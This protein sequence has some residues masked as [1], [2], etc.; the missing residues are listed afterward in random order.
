MRR[1]AWPRLL[2]LALALFFLLGGFVN[3]VPSAEISADYVRWGYPG[4]FP[5]VT[6]SLELVTAGLLVSS[7]TRMAGV[8]IGTLV[9]LGALATLLFHSELLHALAPLA[10]LAALAG[11]VALSRR[12][13]PVRLKEY[14]Q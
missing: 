4:W 14:S 7:R 13:Q 8:G 2:A 12:A 9:M 10:V 5:T 1:I 11:V 3:L 6:G